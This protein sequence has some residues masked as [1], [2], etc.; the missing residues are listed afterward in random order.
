[1]VKILADTCTTRYGFIDEKF[2]EK[3]CQ[4]LELLSQR[5]IKPKQIQRFD[6]RAAKLI[7]HAIDQTLTISIYTENVA[8]L[9]STKLRNY[10]IT[11]GQP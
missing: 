7:T 3:V 11:L 1:M 2:E 10:P 8:P 6:N 9:V 4:V 5:L